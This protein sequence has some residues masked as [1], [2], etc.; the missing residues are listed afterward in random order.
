MVENN[1]TNFS[2][3]Q[4]DKTSGKK[5]FI[6]GMVIVVI[7]VI[8]AAVTIILI[9]SK[10]Q[11]APESTSTTEDLP[12]EDERY[13]DLT[14]EGRQVLAKIDKARELVFYDQNYNEA[15]DIILPIYETELSDSFRYDELAIIIDCYNGLEDLENEK[16]YIEE[17]LPLAEQ[18]DTETY[19]MYSERL[20]QL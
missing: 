12:L 18:F 15:L 11:Q 3:K 10:Q 16:K 8:I 2:I 1:E 5:P 9:N 6:I 17:V 4:T 19:N 13:I 7:M 20:T 14:D